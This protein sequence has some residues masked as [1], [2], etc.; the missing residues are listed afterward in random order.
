MIA[1]LD[2][3]HDNQLQNLAGY[4]DV[5]TTPSIVR[6]VK[7]TKVL[8]APDGDEIWGAH[9]TVWPWMSPVALRSWDTLG[10]N[11][12]SN[13]ATGGPETF[14]QVTVCT[15][16]DGDPSSWIG[17]S[18]RTEFGMSLPNNVQSGMGRLV[19]MGLEIQNTSSDLYKQGSMICYR[20][21]GLQ[22]DNVTWTRDIGPTGDAAGQSASCRPL[23]AP[24]L[25]PSEAT[26]TP[27]SR[28]WPAKEGCYIV[29]PFAGDNAPTIA[30]PISP[31]FPNT[32]SEY[33][34]GSTNTGESVCCEVPDNSRKYTRLAP[35]NVVGAFFSGLSPQTTLQVTV[36]WYYESFP[37]PK[38]ELISL[39][40][41]SCEFDPVALQLYTEVLN[42]LPVGVPSDWNA[43]GD[44]FWDVVTAVKDYAGKIGGMIGGAPGEM[45]GNAAATVAGWARDRYMTAPGSG[46]NGVPR[47]PRKQQQQNQQKKQSTTTTTTKK[48]QQQPNNRKKGAV[49]QQ[50]TTTVTRKN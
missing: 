43:S 50:T 27:G 15:Y 10:G 44:W 25:T 17:D 22:R 16:N 21:Q 11:I 13:I 34:T 38:S 35:I 7:Q 49:A 24:P 30:Q 41:P 18:L 33:D 20:S 47:Q 26:L 45:V 23:V 36:I 19:G 46:G 5:V 2:P 32:Y 8:T 12:L 4:P 28:T 48:V 6:H 14:D 39:A 42:R 1:A 3:F 31:I 37:S 40:K 9:V 29:V